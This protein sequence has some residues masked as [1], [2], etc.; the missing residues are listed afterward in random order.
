VI[1]IRQKIDE[2]P[3]A[4]NKTLS[5]FADDPVFVPQYRYSIL[6]TNMDSSAA[7]L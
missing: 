2:W 7:E 1:D 5:L 4:K 3:D 6:V